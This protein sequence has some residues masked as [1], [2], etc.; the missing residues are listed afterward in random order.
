VIDLAHTHTHTHTH[1]H[2]THLA[3]GETSMN[4]RTANTKHHYRNWW[5]FWKLRHSPNSRALRKRRIAM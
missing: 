2:A 1:V 4:W 3:K 5:R